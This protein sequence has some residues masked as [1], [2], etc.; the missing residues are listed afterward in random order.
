MPRGIKFVL[1]DAFHAG[2]EGQ[3]DSFAAAVTEARRR[4][5]LPFEDPLNAPPCMNWT[6]CHRLLHVIEF[7]TR[8][9]PWRHVS[10]VE[11]VKIERNGNTWLLSDNADD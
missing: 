10:V 11:L 6:N 9:H 5:E 2:W 1:E 7:D 4:S 3:Y 8:Y